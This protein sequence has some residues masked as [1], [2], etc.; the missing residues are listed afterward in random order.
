MS[1]VL[2][3]FVLLGVLGYAGL[4][5]FGAGM[6]NDSDA[7]KEAIHRAKLT[8][9]IGLPLAALIAASHFPGWTAP[10]PG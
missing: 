7:A 6:A 10:P 8:L 1:L 5:W 9:A 2:A 3:V 4:Q